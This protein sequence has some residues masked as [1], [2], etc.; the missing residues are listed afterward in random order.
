MTRVQVLAAM[1]AA[2]CARE[3][4]EVTSTPA[5][6]Q[7]PPPAAAEQPPSDVPAWAGERL[8]KGRIGDESRVV[9]RLRIEN[10]RARGRYFYEA[11]GGDLTLDGSFE[12]GALEL[13]EQTLDGRASGRFRA[14]LQPDGSVTGSWEAVSGK[15]RLPLELRPVMPA[16]E[17]GAPLPVMKKHA[18]LVRSAR[19]RHPLPDIKQCIDDFSYPEVVGAFDAATEDK[20]NT[21]LL[22]KSIPIEADCDTGY[23]Y[24]VTHTVHL[25]RSGILSVSYDHAYCCG[26]HPSYTK[27]FVNLLL[28]SNNELEL[29]GLLQPDAVPKL[30][31]LLTPAVTAT[32]KEVESPDTSEVMNALT[33]SPAD[34]V[35]ED[36]G[37]RLS[38]FNSQPHAI[39]AAYQA[40]YLVSYAELR[41]LL[42]RPGPLD[43]LLTK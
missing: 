11:T 42:V 7:S 2:G 33:R 10:E 17:S 9:V 21:R 3:A 31:R 25:N 43:A 26:A 41:P 30:Q 27:S 5:R 35:V 4:P 24:E 40:G 20:L 28:P 13:T 1:L 34:F 38:A 19:A 12:R 39:Q 32:A 22:P 37:L 15:R 29:A 8:F 14:M 16:W 18:R 6:I 36:S 23:E